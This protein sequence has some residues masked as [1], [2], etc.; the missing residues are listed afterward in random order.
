MEEA[1]Q[2][3]RIIEKLK[4]VINFMIKKLNLNNDNDDI[5]FK[6]FNKK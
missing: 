1:E 3:K 4:K 2:K 6:S 5:N